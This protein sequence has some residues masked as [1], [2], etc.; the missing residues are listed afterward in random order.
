MTSDQAAR[1]VVFTYKARY[2]GAFMLLKVTWCLA[3]AVGVLTSVRFA[4]ADPSSRSAYNLDIDAST[5]DELAV[6]LAVERDLHVIPTSQPPGFVLFLAGIYTVFGHS[7]LA[8]KLTFSALLASVAV[9]AAAIAWRR[10]GP[11]EGAI[12]GSLIMFSPLLVAYAATLQ[13]EIPAAF[14]AMLVTVLLLVRPTSDRRADVAWAAALGGACAAAALV[15]ETLVALFPI[16]LVATAVRYHRLRHWRQTVAIGTVA[17]IAF[18]GPLAAWTW[19]QYRHTGRFVFISDKS[20]MNLRI[21]NNAAANGTYH[22]Q[23]RPIEEPSGWTFITERPMQTLRLALRKILYFWGLLRDPWTVPHPSA[24]VVSR[25]LLN[26]VPFEWTVAVARGGALAAL[27]LVGLL[28]LRRSV[29]VW[30]LPALVLTIM[31]V[32]VVYFASQRF[33]VTVQPQ[34]YILAAAALASGVRR[35]LASGRAA[36]GAT[37]LSVLWVIVAQSFWFPGAYRVEGAALEGLLAENRPDARASHGTARFAAAVAGPRPIAFLAGEAFPRGALAVRVY[38][39]ATDC[40]HPS[41][42]ALAVSVRHA[43]RMPWVKDAFTVGDLCRTPGYNVVMTHAILRD[44]EVIYVSVETLAAVDV[45]VDRVEILFGYRQLR[46]LPADSGGAA[47][48]SQ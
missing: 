20:E 16:A 32:H 43:D 42:P 3:L 4:A 8:A 12:A 15:R 37:V 35:I 33:A 26:Q 36:I 45:W 14:L 21:G 30:P 5:Y 27:F 34:I 7:Y 13:Y 41:A 38:A 31:S 19:A 2:N 28:T 39:R 46:Q 17:T 6:R 9:M 1:R 48:V 10:I 47:P 29:E 11:L 18:A 23:L 25:A 24:V 40:S 22:V 44:D